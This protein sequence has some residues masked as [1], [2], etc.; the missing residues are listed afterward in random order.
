MIYDSF[1]NIH[2]DIIFSQINIKF[3]VDSIMENRIMLVHAKNVPRMLVGAMGIV[4]GPT[5]SV[6][7]TKVSHSFLIDYS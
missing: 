1:W 4:N 2:F 5:K 3:I 7:L 6:S